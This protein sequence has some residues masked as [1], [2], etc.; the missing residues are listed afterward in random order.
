M[1]L[2][3][4]NLLKDRNPLKL[5]TKKSEREL[6]KQCIDS[7]SIKC[8][9]AKQFVSGLSGGNKQK[10]VFAKWIGNGSE[11]LILDCP[12]RGIDVGVKATMYQLMYKYKKEGK[13][14]IMISEELPELIG[15]S[16]RI[17]ILK[18]GVQT[19][20]FKRDPNLRDTDIIGTMI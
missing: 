5:I 1:V 13:S 11:I 14:M 7:M 10:V 19:A 6:A 15:M 8:Q 20:E 16:D 12:T 3:S 4:L 9:G 2:P 17:I 18:D